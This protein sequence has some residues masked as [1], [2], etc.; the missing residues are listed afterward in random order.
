MTKKKQG[1]TQ[2]GKK[3][4][5]VTKEELEAIKALEYCEDVFKRFEELERFDKAH[6]LYCGV[7]IDEYHM[8]HAVIINDDNVAKIYEINLRIGVYD[9]EPDKKQQVEKALSDYHNNV[10]SEDT[11]EDTEEY[12]LIDKP[13]TEDGLN[14]LKESFEKKKR[15]K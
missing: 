6:G 3:K 7:P 9:K 13:L 15:K 1:R 10:V 12:A 8:E 11:E 5:L 4:K 2:Q 14:K